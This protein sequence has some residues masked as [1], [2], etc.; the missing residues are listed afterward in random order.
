VTLFSVATASHITRSRH[1]QSVINNPFT[2][3]VLEKKEEEKSIGHQFLHAQTKVNSCK[4]ELVISHFFYH[5]VVNTA[6]AKSQKFL[7][8][9][10]QLALKH[11]WKP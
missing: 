5:Y 1:H 4:K 11:L 7:Q 6:S 2:T 10:P 9:L 8:T 3:T